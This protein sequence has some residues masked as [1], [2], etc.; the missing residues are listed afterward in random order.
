MIWPFL[1][2]KVPIGG[3]KKKLVNKYIDA[4]SG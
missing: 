4:V 3:E 1:F 2:Y